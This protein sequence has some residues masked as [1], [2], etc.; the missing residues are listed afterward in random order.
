MPFR[1]ILAIPLALAL[2]QTAWAQ[3]PTGHPQV[4]YKDAP[5]FGDPSIPGGGG[6]KSKKDCE[7]SVENAY[8]VCMNN[9]VNDKDKDD[10]CR[11]KWFD[12]MSICDELW[13]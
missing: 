6:G 5:D 1:N 4:Q 13:K 8:R 7:D 9:H 2:G 3:T 11:K 12:G 10:A